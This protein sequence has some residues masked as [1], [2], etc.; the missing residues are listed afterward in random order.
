MN[1]TLLLWILIHSTCSQIRQFSVT[2][3]H[4]HVENTH[5][6]WLNTTK[7]KWHYSQAINL[8]ILLIMF[9]FNKL[10]P[11]KSGLID[12]VCPLLVTA[13]PAE[14][15]FLDLLFPSMRLHSISHLTDE[16]LVN[17]VQGYLKWS[18]IKDFKCSHF[19]LEK[20]PPS[21]L[22]VCVF[23]VWQ[24]LG[25]F[26]WHS[27]LSTPVSKPRRPWEESA[28]C[29]FRLRECW[30]WER[31]WAIMAGVAL[32]ANV[33]SHPVDAACVNLARVEICFLQLK[34]TALLDSAV[35]EK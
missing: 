31:L 1:A 8:L 22:H 33:T 18:E 3:T 13:K 30:G 20:S 17:W 16:Y 35:F 19:H 10:Q 7:I 28:V 4:K 27:G 32:H 11:P 21:L 2:H 23:R 26:S 14:V 6:L 12:Q 25:T 34:S 15:F 9:T 29:L 24:Q 5:L